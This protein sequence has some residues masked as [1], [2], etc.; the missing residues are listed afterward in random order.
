MIEVESKIPEY[1]VDDKHIIV[2]SHW[3]R[4]ALI[5]LVIDNITHTVNASELK[6]AIDNATN[7]SR[8]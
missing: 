4:P 6:S 3:N 7:T 5:V 2:K 8:Y 1:E